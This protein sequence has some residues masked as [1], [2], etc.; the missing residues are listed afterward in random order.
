MY[1][2]NIMK[3]LT[4]NQVIDQNKKLRTKNM[5]LEKKLKTKDALL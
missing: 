5:I 2:E 1:D 3:G 4:L